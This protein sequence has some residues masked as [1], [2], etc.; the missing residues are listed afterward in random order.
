LD[1]SLSPHPT[2]ISYRVP[3][4]YA[5]LMR[6]LM[7]ILALSPSTPS[8]WVFNEIWGFFPLPSPN[9]YIL[10]CVPTPPFWDNGEYSKRISHYLSPPHPNEFSHCL[11]PLHPL[12]HGGQVNGGDGVSHDFSAP[13]PFSKFDLKTRNFHICVCAI[14][15]IITIIVE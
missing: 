9:L 6:H 4:P 13:H 14:S 1:S 7:S 11:L 10:L 8:S 15:K 12:S 2:L 3:L 5:T